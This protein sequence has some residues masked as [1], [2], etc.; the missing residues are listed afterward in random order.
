MLGERDV[1]AYQ[2]MAEAAP[3]LPQMTI[4]AA[5]T[6][7]LPVH[8][9]VGLLADATPL[10]VHGAYAVVTA[11]CV[12]ATLWAAWS[13]MRHLDLSP[14]WQSALLAVPLLNAYAFRYYLLAPGMVADLTFV[15]GLTV[16]INGAL[17]RRNGVLLAGAV[18]AACSRQT[19][20]L[21]LPVLA[22]C[23]V[24]ARRG[25]SGR[26]ARWSL[27]AAVAALPFIAW[28]AVT[29][30]TAPFTEPFGPRIPEDTVLPQL[31]QLPSSLP[32]LV[33]H[34]LR[35]AVPYLVP[36]GILVAVALGRRRAGAPVPPLFWGLLAMS[37]AV[38]AQPLAVR[39]TFPG[40]AF[41][42]PR[43]SALGLMP[44]VLA[45]AVLLSGVHL[46][47]GR[48]RLVSLVAVV[49]V[50]SLH[51][52]YTIVG[53]GSLDRF[54]LVQLVMAAIVGVLLAGVAREAAPGGAAGP[55][56]GT[57]GPGAPRSD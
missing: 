7:R 45:I 35:V 42:E 27:A 30:V 23:V 18:L 49:A 19:A 48:R 54:L 50:G 51:H 29:A 1:L 43:L 22:G 46:R 40:F 24:L 21:A 10:A 39:R 16:G 32:D 33:M 4:G 6:A 14:A 15:A 8:Y 38:L 56:G 12:T 2:L 3:G 9:A 5:Y 53:P 36:A 17:T 11:T 25:E 31:L 52:L 13:A 28:I 20:L 55:D 37:A 34:G 57:T 47:L 41:N 26:V 44:F